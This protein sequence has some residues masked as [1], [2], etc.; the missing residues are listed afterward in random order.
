MVR[1]GVARR[2]GA[3]RAQ[4]RDGDSVEDGARDE[5]ETDARA[6]HTEGK[7]CARALHGSRYGLGCRPYAAAG[8]APA[9]RALGRAARAAT[10]E[11]SCAPFSSASAC[12]VRPPASAAS[13]ASLPDQGATTRDARLPRRSKLRIPTAWISWITPSATR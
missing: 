11:T 6:K 3:V 9:G 2:K 10:S 12:A 4:I 13:M 7:T 1:R 5:R 8:G